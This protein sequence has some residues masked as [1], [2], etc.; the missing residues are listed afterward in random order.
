[1]QNEKISS[2]LLQ[3]PWPWPWLDDLQIRTYP[4]HL[5]SGDITAYQN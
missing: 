2:F 3:W 5:D 4:Y 1:L